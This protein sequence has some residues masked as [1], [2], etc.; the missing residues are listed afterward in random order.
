MMNKVQLSISVLGLT[1]AGIL[2]DAMTRQVVADEVTATAVNQQVVAN[3]VTA[4]VVNQQI[5]PEVI[6][7]HQYKKFFKDLWR[8]LARDMWGYTVRR[9]YSA[10]A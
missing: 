10:I 7:E 4:E 9:Q 6:N 8:L 2:P 1:A 3:E 5:T